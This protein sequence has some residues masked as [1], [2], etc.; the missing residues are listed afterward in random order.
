[1]KILETMS[2]KFI[3][4][5]KVYEISWKEGERGYFYSYIY[6]EGREELDFLDLGDIRDAEKIQNLHVLA[7][8]YILR[9]EN[10]LIR[11]EELEEF[12][13]GTSL[14]QE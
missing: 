10:Q 2:G 6:F 5:E 13:K 1:M 12:L 8:D 3:N 11:Y 9:S 7:V 4:F 14:P